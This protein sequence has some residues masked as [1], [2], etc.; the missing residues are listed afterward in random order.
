MR[1]YLNHQWAI[2]IG[3]FI[4]V[5]L[6]R[7]PSVEEPFESDS[8]ANAYHARLILQGEPLYSTHHPAHQLPAVYYT[9]ALVF[10]IFG[11]SARS[12]KLFIIPWTIV[13]AYLIYLIG[14]RLES[15]ITGLLA[16]VFF[17]ILNSHIFLQGTSAKSVLFVNLPVTAAILLTIELTLR[18]SKNWKFVFT[19]VL[20]AVA[21]LYKSVYLSPLVVTL[22]VV[23]INSWFVREHDRAWKTALLSATWVLIGFIASLVC[24]TVYF[25]GLDLLSRFFLVFT[26]GQKYVAQISSNMPSAAILVAPLFIL[27]FNNIILLLLSIV[28]SIR[29]LRQIRQKHQTDYQFVIVG[30]SVVL[31]F[32]FSIIIAGITRKGWPYYSIIVIPPLVLIAAW[33]IGQLRRIFS[34]RFNAMGYFPK[35]L[36]VA[37][38]LIVI[39]IQSGLTNYKQYYHYALYKL[40]VEMYNEFLT[41]SLPFG[42]NYVKVNKIV[43]YIISNTCPDDYIYIWS[44]DPQIYYL[45]NRRAPIDMIW[46]LYAEATGSYQRIFSPRTKY[47]VVGDSIQA[48]KPEWL[49]EELKKSYQFEAL[50]EDQLIYRRVVR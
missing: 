21:F 50:I 23:F 3:L 29:M 13:I 32:V 26:L 18:G 36:P 48:A 44:N 35:N 25:A 20:C 8:G 11:D 15:K 14:T 39:M 7:L 45:T 47:I 41:K 16:A 22:F 2:I 9:Y 27:A 1:K 49:F 28:G 24:V 40:G 43:E 17:A 10:F 6:L 4:L 38:L 30:L 19:G 5:V 46:P 37:I 33:E 42:E 31:W 12:V 34:R